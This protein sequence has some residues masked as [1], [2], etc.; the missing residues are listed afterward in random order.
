MIFGHKDKIAFFEEL[1]RK[2]A[3]AHSYLFFGSSS[4]GKGT[5]AK[6]LANFLERGVF[7][8]PD[9]PLLNTIFVSPKEDKKS[10]SI[11]AVSELRRF[12][13][14]GAFTVEDGAAGGAREARRIAIIDT[15]EALGREAQ[16]ALLKT[17]EEPPSRSLIIAVANDP[18]ALHAPL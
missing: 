12:L 4:V 1:A 9:K 8:L 13:A 10:I 11:D 16:S 7:N 3:L 6:S 17:V 15:V 14:H 2:D 18:R 5:F